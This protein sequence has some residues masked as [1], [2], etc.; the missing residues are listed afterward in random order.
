MYAFKF[1]HCY[2][3]RCRGYKKRKARLVITI[4]SQGGVVR[5]GLLRK[6]IKLGFLLKIV[7]LFSSLVDQSALDLCT[8]MAFLFLGRSYFQVSNNKGTNFISFLCKNEYF[9][10]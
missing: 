2:I 10:R 7:P 9:R 3:V 8:A 1:W 5:G 6:L 4:K